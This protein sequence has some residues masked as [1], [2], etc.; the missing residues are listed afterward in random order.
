MKTVACRLSLLFSIL[1]SLATPNLFA[2]AV[3]AEWTIMIY[4]NGK[5]NLEPA[6]LYDFGEMAKIGSTASVNF[7]AELGRP[8]KAHALEPG[9]WSGVLRFRIAK[10][11]QPVVAS[12]IDP[13]D[14]D[15]RHADMGNAATLAKFVDWAKQQYPAK[16]YMSLIWSH[17][18]GWRIYVS[19]SQGRVRP[20]LLLTALNPPTKKPDDLTGGFRSVSID[21][22]YG[23]PMYNRDIEDQLRGRHFDIIGFDACLMGMLETG[24]ALRNL[25]TLMVASEELAPDS[26]WNYADWMSQ[27]VNSPNM[28]GSSL[29]KIL[30]AS[31]KA[32]YPGDESR[33]TTMASIDLSKI[34]AFS[35]ALSHFSLTLQHSLPGELN[36][37]AS[38]RRSTQTLGNWS[39]QSWFSCAS[40]DVM[41]FHSVDLGQFLSSYAKATQNTSIKQE[42][43]QL[44]SS[45]KQIPT[46]WFVSSPS[47][48]EYASNYA[49]L[50]IYFP[51]SLTDFNC[52]PDH[53]GYDVQKVR[54]GNVPYPP[55]FVQ[56]EKWADFLHDY[57]MVA[58]N[59]Q[60]DQ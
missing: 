36:T 39:S 32:A 13:N 6:A 45:L 42:A 30:V 22:D 11:M 44:Y 37:L 21:Q 26:G 46:A 56:K 59:D 31:Y 16:K 8:E 47:G 50:S 38:V 1:L 41:L 43:T 9:D 3:P 14:S 40:R 28:D 54:S 15:V 19:V 33:T 18:Q 35:A 27:I 53:D 23:H 5:N 51:G 34:T 2:Q 60:V 57:L 4:M 12:A 24:Y 17:G 55:E 48:T 10:N 20:R 29:G 49:G 7:V 25:A 52:D 58:R